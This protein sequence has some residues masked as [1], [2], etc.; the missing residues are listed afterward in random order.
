V[1]RELEHLERALRSDLDLIHGSA[2]WFQ[3]IARDSLHDIHKLTAKYDGS[4]CDK[5]EDI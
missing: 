2:R 4:V 5:D 3:R 1:C